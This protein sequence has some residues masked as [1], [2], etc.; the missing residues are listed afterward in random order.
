MTAVSDPAIYALG[1][2]SFSSAVFSSQNQHAPDRGRFP[3][4]AAEL[5]NFSFQLLEFR[6]M[7][8]S[9]A[10]QPFGAPFLLGA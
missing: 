5:V 3:H 2:M 9:Q 7:V 1:A 8:R 10:A 6:V 4:I